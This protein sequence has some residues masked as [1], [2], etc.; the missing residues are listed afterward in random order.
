MDRLKPIAIVLLCSAVADQAVAQGILN[1]PMDRLTFVDTVDGRAFAVD[2]VGSVAL[3]AC[4]GS[5]TLVDASVAEGR[6]DCD[7]AQSYTILEGQFQQ[8][9]G[10]HIADIWAVW[11]VLPAA[12]CCYWSFDVAEDA[13]FYIASGVESAGQPQVFDLISWAA[14]GEA[15]NLANLGAETAISLL[16]GTFD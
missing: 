13:Y 11:N 7:R 2:R 6:T 15:M 14:P 12:P 9:D 5:T 16:Y 1:C 8:A 4:G 3:T 10:A